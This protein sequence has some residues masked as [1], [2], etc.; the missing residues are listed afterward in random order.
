MSKLVIKVGLL[1]LCICMAT[2]AAT[3]L[4]VGNAENGITI[5]GQDP[6][7][8]TLRVSLGELEVVPVATKNGAF[9]VLSA[10]GLSLSQQ[11][12]EPALP[13]ANQLIAVPEGAKLSL[14]VLESETIE[15]DLATFGVSTLLMPAQPSLSKSDNPDNV[16]FEYKE[17]AYKTAGYYS[18]PVASSNI[19]GTMRGFRVGL[20]S[21]APVQYDPTAN[22]I[23]VQN[24]IT[25]RVNFD[26]ADWSATQK[27]FDRTY[28]P[29]FE[30]AYAQLGNYEM[31]NLQDKSDLVK[32]PVKFV[33]VSARMFE[34]QLQPFIAWKVKKGFKVIVAYTDVIGT[35]T[36][37]IKTYLQGLY[38]AGTPSDPAPSFVLLVGDTP[39]I[40]AFAGSAGSHV[41]DLRYCEYTGDN[42]PEV[43]YG[44]FSAQTTAQLQP[45][46]DKT[47]EYEQYL[48]PNPAYLGE[49][50]LIAGVDGSY[51]PTYGNGQ[52]NYGTNLY[53]NA[54][55]GITP[56]VWLYPASDG[57]GASAAIIQTVNNGVGYI[58]YTAHGSH[59]GWADPSFTVSDINGLTNA[60]KYGLSV[61][62]CCVTNTFAESTPCFGEAWMQAANKGGIGYIGASNNSYWDEDYWW[63]VGGGKAIVAAGPPYDATRIG[64]Y[65]GAFHDHGEPVTQHYITNFA[66]NMCGNLAVEQSTSSRKQYYWEIYHLMGDPSVISYLKVPTANGVSYSASLLM[67]S[68]TFTVNADPGSYVGISANGVLHGAGYV[69]QTGSVVISLTSFGQPVTAD[70]VVTAQNKIPYLGTVQVIAPSGP[71]VIYQ[72]HTI[73]DAAGNNNG[74]VDFGEA[75]QLGMQI[76]NVGPDAANQVVATLSTDDAYVTITD[77]TENYGTIAGNF[78]NA[79][80]ANA[81]AFNVDTS[82]P[83][84]HK[85]TFTLSVTGSEKETWV[86]TFNV[87]THSPTVAFLSFVVND[88]SGNNNGKLDPGETANMTVTLQNSGTGTA[89]NVSALLTELDTYLDISD[90]DGTFGDV[91]GGGGTA[92]NTANTYTV[93][94]SPTSPMGHGVN[95]KLA[96]TGNG[97]FAATVY[98]TLTIGDRVVFFLEDFA[99]EQGW[100]GLGGDAEWQ[101]AAAV[102][103]SGDPA[104]DHSVGTDKMVL[105]NDLTA[106]GTY[107][108]NIAATG[109][110]YSPTIDCSNATSVSMTYYHQLGVESSSYDHAYLE[111][112]DG[113][114]WVQLYTNAAT[115]NEAGW[116]ES[117][118]DLALS[119]DNN[120]EFQIRFGFGPTDGS[121]VYG[122]WNIDD[123]SLKGYVSGSGGSSFA[124]IAPTA[125]SDSLVE[126]EEATQ[127]IVIKN[128]GEATL[129]IRFT[130]TV[131]W[132]QC[133]AAM[134]YIP[135][136]D[137][138]VFP[139]TFKGTGLNPGTHDGL[140]GYSSNDPIHATGN[141]NASLFIYAPQM[142]IAPMAVTGHCPI[143]GKDTVAVSINNAGDGKLTYQVDCDEYTKIAFVKAAAEPIGY[144][145]NDPDKGGA[146]E[147]Y[148]ADVVKGSGGPDAYGN[149]WVDSDDPNGPEYNWIDIS[150]TGTAVSGLSDDNFVGPF[151]IGFTFLHYGTGYTNFYVG[152]NGL[153]GFGPTADLSTLTNV[154]IPST[155]TPN[156][157][158]AWFWDDL[159]INDEDSPG[160]RVLYE[161]VNGE[162]VISFLNYPEYE[163]G[164]NPGEVIT[165]QVILSPNGNVKIQYQSIAQGVDIAGCT[166]GMENSGG[167][168]GLMATFNANYLHNQ[169]AIYMGA[170]APT[171]MEISSAGGTIAPHSNGTLWVYFDALEMLDSTCTGLLSI[172]SNDPAYP[173]CAVPVTLK[174]GTFYVAGDG[175]G[176]GSVN[177]SDAVYVINYV[178]A[179]GHAPDPI[180]AGDANCSGLVNISDAVYLIQYI[181]SGGT[182]PCGL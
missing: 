119:A 6:S 17:A 15:Y 158:I 160:G 179:G 101:I 43:Y 122:G 87:T 84:G 98:F 113:S 3:T 106:S 157:I 150:A 169:M 89:Y 166:V 65:D 117:V 92:T 63:G 42:L 2:A 9:T 115:L 124:Q 73:N 53:F 34:A 129:R 13:M 178:F 175:N 29:V 96:I 60:H 145:I 46:I 134:N 79:T 125:L 71:Y 1:L 48:M 61:G 52:I 110:I 136:G 152:S 19:S 118:Y 24:E 144:R 161:V 137:S 50:T 94:A 54:A 5:L 37:A 76:Q 174:V 83:D 120:P 27:A 170:Q 131:A 103:G 70:V 22:K 36:T 116:T 58:N 165:A 20:I 104:D 135:I 81:F 111:V 114:A 23:R 14:E 153:I 177:I 82:T 62:N 171:W 130:P 105:G 109:W 142:V 28:S 90:A 168:I 78:G 133:A 33:I 80:I 45:Q 143:G 41:T 112:Y 148:F 11:V 47:L 139:V 38:N 30:P 172:S 181:F 126:G 85:V 7:G 26:G 140:L 64:A 141:L 182:A 12:G 97:G 86:S 95:C 163:S 35:T 91:A 69:D 154:S 32:Y 138:L 68:T 176:D 121:Q 75:I 88:V 25:V 167:T 93:S 59:D 180:E 173:L 16:P 108:N 18:L 40:P 155:A 107:S 39:Q 56:H 49:T 31:M 159:N 162:L 66:I 164:V 128:T 123:I 74:L 99:A 146:E 102:G 57:A 156:N 149:I 8:M 77:A 44:R 51:A 21:V 10:S 72:S 151:P 100:T 4:K 132:I 147:P 127:T 55:H 67:T